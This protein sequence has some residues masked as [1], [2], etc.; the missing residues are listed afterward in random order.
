[1]SDTKRVQSSLMLDKEQKPSGAASEAV[2]VSYVLTIELRRQIGT[3]NGS[4]M[5]VPSHHFIEAPLGESE[6]TED[7]GFGGAIVARM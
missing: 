6:W 5:R 7:D 3:W 1:V 2:F 4:S